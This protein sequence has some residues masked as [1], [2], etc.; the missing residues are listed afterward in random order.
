MER[1]GRWDLGKVVE[2][3]TNECGKDAQDVKRYFVAFWMNYR[4]IH[5]WQKVVDAA[6]IIWKWCDPNELKITRQL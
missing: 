1:Y 5:D 2:D 4:R 6:S 3:V